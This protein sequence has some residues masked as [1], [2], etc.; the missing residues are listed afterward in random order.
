MWQIIVFVEIGLEQ[1]SQFALWRSDFNS[2]LN[3][4]VTIIGKVFTRK[5]STVFKLL[6]VSQRS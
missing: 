1:V 6:T 4:G 5:L 2:S 3:I